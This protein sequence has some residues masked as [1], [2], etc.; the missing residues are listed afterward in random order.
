M[1]SQIFGER[2]VSHLFLAS[3]IGILQT[4]ESSLRAIRIIN[5]DPLGGSMCKGLKLVGPWRVD[6]VWLLLAQVYAARLQ[7]R[8]LTVPESRVFHRYWSWANLLATL[9]KVLRFCL[10]VKHEKVRS[11]SVK[12]T[13]APCTE[14]ASE[15]K[16]SGQETTGLYKDKARVQWK[17]RQQRDAGL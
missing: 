3:G 5:T 9:M 15:A 2:G 13:R 11:P 1:F 14:R 4:L 16:L 7:V 10:Q 6:G 17:S 8:A 12:E